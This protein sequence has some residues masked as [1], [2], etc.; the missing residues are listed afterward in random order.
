MKEEQIIFDVS[1]NIFYNDKMRFCRSI[2]SLAVGA[3][4]KLNNGKELFIVDGFSASGIRGIRYAKENKN[5]EN[6][7]FIDW[8]KEAI[9]TINKNVKIN[10]IKSKSKIIYGDYN[11]SIM[12]MN[13]EKINFIELDPFGTP[14]PYLFDSIRILKN[15]KIAF[16]SATATDVAVLCGPHSTACLKKYHSKSLNNEFT[17]ENGI[18]ILLKRIAEVSMEFNLG[19]TPLF[20]LSDQ[21]YLKVLV[22][23]KKGDEYVRES[24]KKIGYVSYCH[25]CGRRNYG[26]RMKEECICGEMMDWTGPLWIGELHN[27]ETI[28]KM[29][30]INNERG[31]EDKNK[32]NKILGL[33]NNEIGFPPY[34]FNIHQI[35]HRNKMEFIPKIETV[36][37]KLIENGYKATRTHFSNE[38]IKT[39]ATMDKIVRTITGKTGKMKKKNR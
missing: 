24:I 32:I 19:I 20:S 25:S 7:L 36:V 11:E 9:K 23:L 21:H 29:K 3:I 5:V 6:V 34:Y 10:R 2:S 22:M 38:S 31:Y 30:L 37:E 16:L 17:H 13:C 18:R 39:D 15:K 8:N 26:N 28:E 14:S 4:G 1:P 35:A 33:M 27:K 12:K